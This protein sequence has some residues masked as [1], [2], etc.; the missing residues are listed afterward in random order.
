MA[1]H[2]YVLLGPEHWNKNHLAKLD[3]SSCLAKTQIC[4]GVIA[5]YARSEQTMT[6]HSD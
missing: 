3:L 1:S 2:R 4:Q 5:F 6:K